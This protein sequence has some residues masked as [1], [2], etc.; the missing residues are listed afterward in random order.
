M[1]S[2]WEGYYLD[3][4]TATRERAAIHVMRSGLQVSTEG[5]ATFWW[6]YTETRQTQ[7]FYK[8]EQVRLERGGELPEALLISDTAFLTALRQ[9]APDAGGRFHDPARRSRRG[10]LVVLAAVAAAGVAGALYLWAIPGIAVLVAAR[11]PVAWEE[12]LGRS[13]VEHLAPPGERCVGP[14]LTRAIGDVV[15][16]LTAPGPGS[17]YTVRVIVVN[18]PA[19]NA[20]AAP[21]GFIVV[22]RGLLE[23]TRTPEE[24]AGVLA[25]EFQH[26]R[27]RHATR[28]LLE[29]AGTGLLVA[30]LASDASGVMA[31]GLE[32]ARTLGTLRYSRRQE[33]EADADGMRMLVAARIDPAGMIEFFERLRREEGRSLEFL[34]YLST[35]PSTDDRIRK[36][37]ALAGE[38]RVRPVALLTDYDWRDLRSLC[39]PQTK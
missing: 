9:L 26:V 4:R 16:R 14:M 36:L 32:S 6:P 22:F 29:H 5:G 10:A 20:L 12:R 34:T 28:T 18:D 33:E 30:A 8:G 15:G 13:V 11:V 24:L 17:P 21:G 19:V 7:G 31:F 37:E 2:A 38:S 23:R 1:R 3:G 27:H 39:R 25:H 35:H